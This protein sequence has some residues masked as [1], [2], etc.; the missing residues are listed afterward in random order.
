[1]TTYSKEIEKVISEYNINDL[2]IANKLYK[3]E[4]PNVPEAT[5]YK[6]LGRLVERNKLIRVEK[7]IYVRPKKTRFGT[8][9][10]SE[11]EIIAHYIGNQS[12]FVKGYKLFNKVG[13]TTQ[14]SKVTE[15][16]SNILDERKKTVGRVSISKLNLKLNDS[17]IQAI[18]ILE[19]LEN[20]SKIEDINK[21]AFKRYLETI[22]NS[23]NKASFEKVMASMR[24]KKRTIAFLKRILD[25][26]GIPNDLSKYL[27]SLSSYRI[28]LEEVLD[29]TTRR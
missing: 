17:V 3:S 23:Y 2:I 19:I 25:I 16:Y 15:I 11:N 8:V 28:P 10:A 24:Y 13:L 5:F 14:V 21:K 1:M 4:F 9:G 26:Y 22:A 18:E 27:S 7:G 6:N 12:G 29:E 20:I